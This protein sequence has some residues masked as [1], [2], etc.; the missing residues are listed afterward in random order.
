MALLYILVVLILQIEYS[1]QRW[2]WQKNTEPLDVAQFTKDYVKQSL[3]SRVL[4]NTASF[5]MMLEDNI[6]EVAQLLVKVHVDKFLGKVQKH[7]DNN[8]TKVTIDM[9][10]PSEYQI[11]LQDFELGNDQK[12]R[13]FQYM[14]FLRKYL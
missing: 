11:Q 9:I 10:L 7:L 8:D 6:D 5:E 3:E 1:S 2:P 14:I 13:D 4:N 12:L